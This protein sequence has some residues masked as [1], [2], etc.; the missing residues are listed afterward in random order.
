MSRAPFSSE[1]DKDRTPRGHVKMAISDYIGKVFPAISRSPREEERLPLSTFSLKKN[2]SGGRRLESLLL[3]TSH[4]GILVWI[5]DV[6]FS[7][8]V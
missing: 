6:C 5:D 8:R 7:E 4:Q 3:W 1:G 2:A